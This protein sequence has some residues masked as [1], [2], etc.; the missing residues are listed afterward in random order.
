M[1]VKEKDI[2]QSTMQLLE[3]FKLYLEVERNLSLH[4]VNAYN[5]DLF[6]FLS[7]VGVRDP[8]DLN[9]KDIRVYLSDIQFKNY[10]KTTVSR[11]IAAIRTFYRY[12]YREKL[13]KANPAD[14][15]KSPRKIKNLPKFLTDNEVEQIFDTI[16]TNSSFGY[17]DRVILELLYATGMR[18]SELCNLDLA[19]LNLE[20]QEI[21][22][23]GK[24]SK[25][26]IVLINNRAKNFLVEYID[27]VRPG[28]L[29]ENMD[30]NALFINNTGFR[31]QQRSIR[32]S[33]ADI[34][35][36]LQLPKKVS[37]HVFRHSFATRLLER[38][39][40]LRVV[41]ELLGHASISNTQI[42][43]HVS[44]ERLRQ[45]YNKAHPRAKID[46]N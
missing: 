4:T 28:L 7:W 26:R 27:K 1:H 16:N 34:V 29:L 39:A 35:K 42:Y 19:D 36:S 9:H 6:N 45:A 21:T 20:G 17:R 18:I 41:Q 33:L 25:E 40:D 31:L 37:P 3:E 14:N 38:G 46:P 15:I 23:F 2:K 32:R 12:L 44:T 43:T 30:N 11:K 8:Q 22:V 13:I 24:G 5:T 10:S